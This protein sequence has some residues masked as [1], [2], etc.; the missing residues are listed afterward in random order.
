MPNNEI[1]WHRTTGIVY[2]I[3]CA[4]CDKYY[5][6]ESS[7]AFLRRIS[8]HESDIRLKR[9]K[10][11]LAQHALELG[12]QPNFD[13][14]VILHRIKNTQVRLQAESF[15]TAELGEKALNRANNEFHMKMWVAFFK[16][17]KSSDCKK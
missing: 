16:N 5:V 2:S 4:N 1:E 12:H 3:P 10:S 6:G 7:R 11:R 13:K 8:E 17:L 9:P 15:A 14:A